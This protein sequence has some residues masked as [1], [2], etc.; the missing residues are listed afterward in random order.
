MGNFKADV[1]NMQ[2][3]N[4]CSSTQLIYYEPACVAEHTELLTLFL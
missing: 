1:V 2:A 4:L 3:L